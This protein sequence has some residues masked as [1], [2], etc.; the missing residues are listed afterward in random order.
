MNCEMVLALA[1][2]HHMVFRMYLN[3]EEIVNLL[4]RYTKRYLLVE[5]IDGSD[6][7]IVDFKQDGFEW[8]TKENFVFEIQK[9]FKIQKVID[10]TPSETRCIFV[11][12][13]R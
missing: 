9:K 2:V 10:S 11:C 4:L 13:K 1:I 8:Y 6:K 7:F 12:E 3:F 5:W